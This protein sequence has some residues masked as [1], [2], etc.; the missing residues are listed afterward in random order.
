[1]RIPEGIL[2]RKYCLLIKDLC[3]LPVRLSDALE[4]LR[5]GR[6]EL[7]AVPAKEK[8]GFPGP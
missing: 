2:K 7:N 8:L 3:F 6:G 1:V 5:E 4:G